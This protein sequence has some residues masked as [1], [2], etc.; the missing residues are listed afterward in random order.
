MSDWR[1]EAIAWRGEAERLLAE[2]DQLLE[3]LAEKEDFYR[4][5]IRTALHAPET[6]PGRCREVLRQAL[7]RFE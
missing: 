5:A 6:G 7:I 1:N 3:R 2:R 4:K